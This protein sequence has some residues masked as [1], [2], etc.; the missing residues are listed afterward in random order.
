MAKEE[1]NIGLDIGAQTIKILGASRERDNNLYRL[2]FF[3]Q[4]ETSGFSGGRV[5]EENSLS[6][7][8]KELFEKVEEKYNVRIESATV[9]ISSRTLELL[10]SKESVSVSGANGRVSELDKQRVSEDIKTMAVGNNKNILKVFPKEWVLDGERDI[11]DP[12]GLQGIRLELV[13]SILTC[14]SLDK[15]VLENVITNAKVQVDEIIPTPLADA[16]CLL[17][18][19]EKE[20][21]VALINIGYS[22]TS[23]IVYEEGKVLDLAVFP[24]GSSHITNDIAIGLVT[25][26]DIA[27]KVKIEFGI[28]GTSSKKIEIK[29]EENA[30][31]SLIFTEKE[32]RNIVVPRVSQILGLINERLKA[33]D[34]Y[35]K[36]P[37]GIVLTGGG[38]KLKGL[39][40]FVKKEC[41]LPC[42]IKY[43]RNFIGFEKED[44]S[45]STVCGL[46]LFNND[47][48]ED[49]FSSKNNFLEK[50]K[51]FLANFKP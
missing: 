24:V 22:T 33:I 28:T 43:S 39:E 48:E 36:L 16:I 2:K 41:G 32:L 11:S 26:I 5:R 3:E 42:K 10:N 23:L 13:A 31:R 44:P 7:K 35:A 21:G 49:D 18:N 12:F 14:F 27:E 4:I 45:Y 50:I 20:R 15:E 1:I 40:E 6:K 25:E 38:S 34:R 9:N 46:V 8:I 19:E 37:A 29:D 51:D 17:T 47:L 30:E